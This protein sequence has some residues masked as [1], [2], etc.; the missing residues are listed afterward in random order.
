MYHKK[1][2]RFFDECLKEI[3]ECWDTSLTREGVEKEIETLKMPS[4]TD[5]E[6]KERLNTLKKIKSIRDQFVDVG[7][8]TV[9][10]DTP[11][12]SGTK[13]VTKYYE[14]ED[15]GWR[16]IKMNMTSGGYLTTRE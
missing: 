11:E 5:D 12:L 9:T 7:I 1:W 14:Y 16:N 8:K 6:I 10:L 13:K 3:N 15:K 2:S 4:K